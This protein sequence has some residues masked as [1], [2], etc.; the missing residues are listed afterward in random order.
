MIINFLINFILKTLK[1]LIYNNK[2]YL[3]FLK[4]NYSTDIYY[5]KY[6]EKNIYLYKNLD[7]FIKK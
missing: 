3:Y 6:S 1:L 2:Q 5:D 4:Y 7:V